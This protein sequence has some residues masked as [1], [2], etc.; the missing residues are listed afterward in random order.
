[1]EFHR[2]VPQYMAIPWL[3]TKVIALT[4]S[5]KTAKIS[6]SILQNTLQKKRGERGSQL[7]LNCRQFSETNFLS[8][9]PTFRNRSMSFSASVLC[10]FFPSVSSCLSAPVFSYLVILCPYF[11]FF[12]FSFWVFRHARPRGILISC[13]SHL[14]WLFSMPRSNGYILSPSQM[15]KLLILFWPLVFAI[16]FFWSLLT[17]HNLRVE[18]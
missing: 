5:N 15:T 1:M 10:L 2:D 9:F 8:T 3:M 18:M 14:I 16:L 12:V 13:L 4:V 6:K 7:L 11:P 17:A